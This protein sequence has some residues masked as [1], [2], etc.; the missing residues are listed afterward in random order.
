MPVARPTLPAR[1]AG[2]VVALLLVLALAPAAVAR[3]APELGIS[4]FHG[5][6]P[7]TL[8]SP[9]S[10]GHQVGDLRVTSFPV[11]DEDGV[12]I[13]RLD[14]SLLTTSVDVPEPGAE[15]RIS[16]LIFVFGE[17]TDQIAVSGSAY[18][19]AGGQT[20]ALGSIVTR[21]IVG[22]SGAWAG[23]S[24]WV[25]SERLDDDTWRHTFHLARAVEPGPVGGVAGGIVRTLLGEVELG[26]V[27]G[28]TLA[29][30]HYTVPAG[31][32]LVPHVH[33]G[34]QV[35]R[36]TSGTLTYEVI[37]GS[38]EVVRADGTR[39]LVEGGRRI[40]LEAGDT[41]IENPDVSHFGAN[42][43]DAP[44]EIHAAS[45]LT[46]GSPPALPLEE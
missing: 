31:E 33:P 13:G 22:G 3:Q 4:V 41:V 19:P 39:E 11:T 15:T 34:Y 32:A 42:E 26:T 40:T 24:G 21:P 29:L 46:T 45:L 6:A 27:E 25:E 37:A 23:A 1:L 16:T 17:G 43:S 12:V 35:A 36:I 7:T 28:L 10:D 20:I 30:W 14:A 38:V 44:V 18:Y 2:A 8:V 9:G 5:P